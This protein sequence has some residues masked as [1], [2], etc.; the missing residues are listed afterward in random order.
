MRAVVQRVLRA[1]VT[2]D[3]VEAARIGQGCKGCESCHSRFPARS[4]YAA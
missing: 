1:N 4:V 3:G 2:I